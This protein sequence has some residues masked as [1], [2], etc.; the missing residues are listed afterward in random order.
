MV[1]LPIM[2][3]SG[4]EICVISTKAALAQMIIL[5]RLALQLALIKGVMPAKEITS[6]E[7]SLYALPEAVKQI[8]NTYPGLI[9]KLAVKH[10]KV[11]NWLYLGRGVYYPIALEAALKMKEVAYLHAEGMPAGFLKHG[12]LADR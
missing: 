8:L 12:T 7:Q 2:Q 5:L 1:D 11:K 9:N 3:G 6:L 4:P 10:R